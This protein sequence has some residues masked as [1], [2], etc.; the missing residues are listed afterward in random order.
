MD[1]QETVTK[2]S[3]LER[4]I[5]PDIEEMQHK[6]ELPDCLRKA[7]DAILEWEDVIDGKEG[8][9]EAPSMEPVEFF[10]RELRDHKGM[11]PEARQKDIEAYEQLAKEL[12]KVWANP[13]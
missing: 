11:F 2:L 5:M 7:K 13:L 6:G 1:Y 3:E 9:E 8:L 10:A 4:K 12:P